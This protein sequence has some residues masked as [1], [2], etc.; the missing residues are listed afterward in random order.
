MQASMAG[1]GSGLLGVLIF[2][3]SLPATRVALSGFNPMFLTSARAVVAALLGIALL[4]LLRQARPERRDVISLLI[5]AAGVV[6]GFPLLTALAL[7]H[8]TAAHSIVFI[9]LLPLATALFGML[10]GMERPKP[11]FWVFSCTGSAA[12]G[13]YALSQSADLSLKGDLLMLAA[14][15]VCGFG[16]AEGGALSRRLGGWQVIS[17]A[18]ALSLP[19]MGTLALLTWPDSLTGIEMPAWVG[20][21]YVSIFSMLVGFIFWYRGLA[22]GGIAGVGQL[23]LLQPFFGLMLASLLLHEPVSS[24]ML[25]VTTL[26]VGCVAGAKRFA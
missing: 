15:I 9:G 17:W 14:V 6:V 20:L 10:R 23:Q 2:S 7:Q 8:V 12:V 26:V 19:V 13:A 5:V 18:L 4:L 21:G 11:L 3:G 16:Y 25:L 24:T 22:I 1:W